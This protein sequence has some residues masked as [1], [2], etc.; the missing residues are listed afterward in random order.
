MHLPRHC[1]VAGVLQSTRGSSTGEE[2]ES[3]M[4][5]AEGLESRAA[6]DEEPYPTVK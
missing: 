3:L 5:Q 1:V 4:V 6:N 2:K